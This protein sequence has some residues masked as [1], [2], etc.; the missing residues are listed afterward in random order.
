M[1]AE[2]LAAEGFSAEVLDAVDALTNRPGETRMQAAARAKANPIALVV[3]LADNAENMDLTR[4]PQPTDKDRARVREHEQVR[5]FL[6][7]PAV[8]LWP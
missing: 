4:I 2:Q 1:T 6:L 8:C 7:A 5:A 3:K